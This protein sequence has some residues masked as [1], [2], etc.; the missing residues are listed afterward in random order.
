MHGSKF[1]QTHQLKII[2]DKRNK[3]KMTVLEFANFH[4]YPEFLFIKRY[5]NWL[6]NWDACHHDHP[7]I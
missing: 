2:L 3:L 5:L 1:A 6:T 7:S 4:D